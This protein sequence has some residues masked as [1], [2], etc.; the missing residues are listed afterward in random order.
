[1][2]ES[3]F[4]RAWRRYERAWKVYRVVA[5]LAILCIAVGVVLGIVEDGR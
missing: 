1:M 5:V 4:D 2:E 3:E